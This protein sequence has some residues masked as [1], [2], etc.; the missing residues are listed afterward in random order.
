[1][2]V[3]HCLQLP[4]ILLAPPPPNY[5]HTLSPAPC[6]KPAYRHSPASHSSPLPLWDSDETDS[7]REGQLFLGASVMKVW[8]SER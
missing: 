3:T 2:D 8:M 1:M 6:N 5:T 7:G 4:R